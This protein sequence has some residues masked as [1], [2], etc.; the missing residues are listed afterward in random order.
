MFKDIQ[1]FIDSKGAEDPALAAAISLA[2]GHLTVNALGAVPFYEE[3]FLG[4][5]MHEAYQDQHKATIAAAEARAEAAGA[6]AR[7][8]CSSVESAALVADIDL[9][10]MDVAVHGRYTDLNV[11]SARSNFSDPRLW[12][13]LVTTLVFDTGRPVLVAP[14]KVTLPPKRVAVGWNASAQAVRAVHDA[15]PLLAGAEQVDV[16]LV[17][18]EP[19]EQGHGPEPGADIARHLA[20]LGLPNIMV[21]RVASGGQSVAQT[22]LRTAV[23]Q[24]AD[25]IVM[26]AYGHSRVWEVILGGAT[27]DMLADPKI[28]IFLAH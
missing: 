10:P 16:V 6:L 5:M 21:Q 2:A 11:I 12:D 25:M 24:A 13:R 17:D 27:K 9:L 18:P 4:A 3:Y 15:L 26:G 7:R 20:R 23:D 1:V 8:E 28:P 22:L 14:A 19:T